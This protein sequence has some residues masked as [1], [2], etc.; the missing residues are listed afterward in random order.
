[1]WRRRQNIELLCDI[2][3]EVLCDVSNGAIL[4]VIFRIISYVANLTTYT[5][6]HS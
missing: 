1:M 6:S 2:N 4:S 3:K 5:V